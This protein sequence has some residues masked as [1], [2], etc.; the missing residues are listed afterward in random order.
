MVKAR[1]V[2]VPP[3]LCPPEWDDG[4]VALAGADLLVAAGAAVLLAGLEGLNPL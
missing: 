3:L 1:R 4:D 2:P